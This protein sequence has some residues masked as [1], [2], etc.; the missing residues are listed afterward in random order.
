MLIMDLRFLFG[1]IWFDVSSFWGFEQ[2]KT[3]KAENVDRK[4]MGAGDGIGKGKE[5]YWS[6]LEG[7]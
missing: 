4:V 6:R 2:Y 5:G 1:D 7:D 3:R